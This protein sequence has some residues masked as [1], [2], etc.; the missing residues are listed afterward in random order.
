MIYL[1]N[2]ATT[3][4]KPNCVYE[5]LDHAN[6]Y[7]AFNAGRGSYKEAKMVSDLIDDTREKIADMIS[8][9]KDSVYFES[10]ATEA[11]NIIINGLN[12][13]KGD[14][15]YISPFEH[16]AVVRPLF[17]LKKTKGINIKVIPFNRVT[18]EVETAKLNDSF[19]LYKPKACFLSHISNV[20][21][22]VLP[23]DVIFSHT[24]E[25]NCINVLDCSQ[26]FGTIL[27]DRQHA[28]FLV[29]AGHKS[30]YA[31][32]GVA[33]FINITNQFLSVYKSGGTGSD[34][35]NP[36]MPL[37]GASRFET[38]SI[39]SVAVAGLN[40]SLSWIKSVE[41]YEHEKEL[42]RYLI[43]RLESLAFVKIIK[44]KEK[45]I[46]GIVSILV[47][48]YESNDVGTILSEDYDICVRTGYHCAPFIHDF[49]NTRDYGGTVRISL[50]WFNNFDDIDKLI[51][52]LETL[53]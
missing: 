49:T 45:D 48:G 17:N 9:N 44:P 2:A 31:S 11:L 25:Y 4:P 43:Q 20:T 27:P 7:L 38:G 16:N 24:K 42:T 5:A 22:Y 37:T 3:Y 47:D 46:I 40:A 52:A 8:V 41:I 10:S 23:V 32:F 6:R 36:D 12:L 39:N 13:E 34:S 26:S 18:W 53:A 51:Q 29:F 50:S 19:L 33:G 30:L 1:D 14:T 28:D 35:L 15:V 21:G